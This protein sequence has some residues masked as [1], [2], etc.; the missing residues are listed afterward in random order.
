MALITQPTEKYHC[1]QCGN[2]F[3][4]V[5]VYQTWNCPNCTDPISIKVMIEDFLHSC[6]R[7]K[8]N[9][10]G[11]DDLVTLEN[12]HIHS[13]IN[14]QQN[15]DTYRVA[16]EKYGVISLKA[17]DFITKINGS[18]VLNYNISRNE[19]NNYFTGLSDQERYF[20]DLYKSNDKSFAYNINDTLRNNLALD[21]FNLAIENL[22]SAIKKFQSQD[23][24]TLHRATINALV[25]PFIR[26]NI[27]INPDYLS[28]ATDVDSIERHFTNS[29]NP[30]YVKIICPPNTN[31]APMEANP[32]FGGLENEILLGRNNQFDVTENRR[33]ENQQEIERYLGKFYAKG[34][35]RLYLYTF[36]YRP[37]PEG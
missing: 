15:G 26:N 18:W 9:E 17:N 12:K 1:S 36:R 37:N 7:V 30:A 29:D 13:V 22:D 10:L 19:L 32:Q 5:Q 20:I 11:K 33:T 34:V 8:P 35:Q 27:Y 16:L 31:M 21:Q 3:T 24:I 23:E 25:S 28:L 6:H 2:F 4:Y 14:I